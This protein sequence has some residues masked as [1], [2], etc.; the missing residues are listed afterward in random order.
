MPRLDEETDT[1]PSRANE[2]SPAQRAGRLARLL[3]PLL[4]VGLCLLVFWP[5]LNHEFV[6]W[7][8]GFHVYENPA[9][10][11]VT[12][13]KARLFWDKPHDFPLTYTLWA[14]QARLAPRV[15]HEAGRGRLQPRLFHAVNLLLHV[16]NALMVY[17]ILRMVLASGLGGRRS[18]RAERDGPA[19]AARQLAATVGALLFAAHPLQVEPVAWISALK[20]V[21][22]GFFA[23]LAV[24]LYLVG[25]GMGAARHPN[26][27]G[28][29][30]RLLGP[31]ATIAFVLALLAKPTAVVTPFIAWGLAYAGGAGARRPAGDPAVER[32]A[33]TRLWRRDLIW[34]LAVATAM[35]LPLAAAF[36]RPQWF[37][38]CWLLMLIPVI[39]LGAPRRK[40]TNASGSATAGRAR[41]GWLPAGWLL[42]AV[43][44]SL[45]SKAGQPDTAITFVTPLWWR[46]A[47]ALDAVAFYL[48]KLFVPLFYGPDYGRSPLAVLGAARSL[49]LAEAVAVGGLGFL[50]WRSRKRAGWLAAAALVFVLG[51]APELGFVPFGFQDISTVADRYLYLAMVGAALGAAGAAAWI[52]PARF[53][54]VACFAALGLLA[55]RS[56]SQVRVWHDTITLFEHGLRGNPDSYA[57]HNNLGKAF[58]EQR[59]DLAGALQHYSQALRAR[60][61]DHVAR[62]NIGLALAKQGRVDEAVAA[63]QAALAKKA[64]YADAHNNLGTAWSQKGEVVLAIKHW[65]RALAL[66]PLLAETHNNLGHALAGQGRL[67][68]AVRHYREAL[69]LN[70]YYAKAFDNLG[71]ALF[72]RNQPQAAIAQ[73]DAALRANP[74]YA[75]AYNNKGLALAGLGRLD[76]A[77]ACY[78]EALRLDPELLVCRNNLGNALLA[79]EK[80]A[81]AAACYREALRRQ[82]DNAEALN[83]LGVLFARQ[84]QPQ[85]AV[86]YFSKALAARPGYRD[87]ERNLALARRQLGTNAAP[88]AVP[89]R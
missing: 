62:N 58:V 33:E 31:A 19:P 20:D 66:D 87:A 2:A 4:V 76:E 28:R 71:V 35:F 79:Q 88:D 23:L 50:L 42:L 61:N 47:I 80:F 57:S 37:L 9:L 60:P 89:P 69:R 84:G 12:A 29:R 25:A 26:N 44:L 78:R 67:E 8:D 5:V 27:G 74:G 41:L 46:P 52:R 39:G 22:S 10:N 73:Y 43:P 13:S 83:N 68:E 36:W 1:D 59:N 21:L 38:G 82:P 70:P 85:R 18:D 75:E 77:V 3:P 49:L 16:L 81:E 40:C 32:A 72:R 30:P 14:L 48:Y 86:A 24:L 34:L 6:S 64:D 15:G 63:F 56:F 11:P 17:A 54:N 7:D 65:E 55:V 53:R 51:V 45:M